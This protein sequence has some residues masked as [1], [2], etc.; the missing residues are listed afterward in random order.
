MGPVGADFA[1]GHH[2]R[3]EKPLLII[4]INF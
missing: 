3:W 1:F 2:S 4:S